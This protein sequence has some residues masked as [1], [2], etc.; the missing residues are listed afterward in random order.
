MHNI[1]ID[2]DVRDMIIRENR[3]YRI[4]TACTGPA[5]VPTSVKPPKKNDL[6]IPVGDRTL[7]I[8]AVQSM[9]VYNVSMDMLY[10]EEEIDTCPAFGFRHHRY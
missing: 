5:L 10:S 1:T 6:V 2:D 3:D 4:C 7:Y 8:S 9:Y